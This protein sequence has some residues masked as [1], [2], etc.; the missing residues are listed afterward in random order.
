MSWPFLQYGYGAFYTFNNQFKRAPLFKSL[1]HLCPVHFEARL[2]KLLFVFQETS[3]VILAPAPAGG[4]KSPFCWHCASVH[5]WWWRLW[6]AEG[7]WTPSPYASLLL[8]LLGATRLGQLEMNEVGWWIAP[9]K[10]KKNTWGTCTNTQIA[11][12]QHTWVHTL[13]IRNKKI[14]K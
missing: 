2:Q 11:A 7:M 4:K 1:V 8:P 9:W 14:N 12:G 13:S 5:R 10:E 3:S 6:A